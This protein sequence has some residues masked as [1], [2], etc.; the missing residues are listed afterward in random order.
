MLRNFLFYYPSQRKASDRSVLTI[1]L[2]ILLNLGAFGQTVNKFT[3]LSTS[4]NPNLT[5]SSET[6]AVAFGVRVC[7]GQFNNED[8][9]INGSASGATWDYLV[10][11][12]AWIEVKDNT[13]GGEYLEGSYAGFVVDAAAIDII[14]NVTITTYLGNTEKETRS[15]SSL[16]SLPGIFTGAS[17]IGFW[18]TKKTGGGNNNFDRIRISYSALGVVGSRTVYYPEVIRYGAGPALACNTPTSLRLS[19]GS[20]TGHPVAIAESRTGIVGTCVGCT[21]SETTSAIDSDP[22]T[23]AK[24]NML[25]SVNA[26]ASISIATVGQLNPAGTFA[27]FDISNPNVLG[28]ALGSGISIATYLNGSPTGESVGNGTLIGATTSLLTGSGRQIVG[29]KT[30][31]AF[32]EVRLSIRQTGVSLGITEVYGLVLTKFCDDTALACNKPTTAMNPANSVYVDGTH[33]KVTSLACVGCAITNPEHAVDNDPTTVAKFVTV[34]GLASSASFAVS[35]AITNYAENSFAGFEI[36][37]NSLASL[38]VLGTAT[39][40]LLYNGQPVAGSGTGGVVLGVN[41]DII[42]G[43][44]RQTIGVVAKAGVTYNGVKIT[45]NK[46]VGVDLG[47]IKIHG[48]VFQ[49]NCDGTPI[50]CETA[51]NLNLPSNPAVSTEPNFPVVINSARTGYD[52]VACVGCY[53]KDASNV[54]SASTTDFAQIGNLINGVGTSSISVFNPINTYP[55]GSTAGFTV[56]KENFLVALSLFD[57][58]RITTYN[59]GVEQEYKEGSALLN[60]NLSLQ[61]FGSTSDFY[62]VAFITQKPFDEIRISVSSLASLAD[63]YLKVYGSF[64]DTRTAAVEALR[65]YNT[66][67]DNYVMLTGTQAEGSVKVNDKVATGTTYGTPVAVSGNPNTLLPTVAQDGTYTF[68]PTLAGIYTFNVPVCLP[69]QPACFNETLTITVLDNSQS[70]NKPVANDD[71]VIVRGGAVTTPILANIIGNDGPGNS[72]GILQPPT[73]TGAPANGTATIVNGQIQYKPNAEFY[74]E[75]IVTYQIC[76]SPSG[77]CTTA[78]LVV[79]VLYPNAPNALIAS[80]DYVSLEVNQAIT[81]NAANGVLANDND[82]DGTAMVVTAQNTFIA[83]VGT[84]DL[85]ADGSYQFTPQ[86]DFRG[87]AAFTYTVCNS[88]AFCQ[89]ATLYVLSKGI[90]NLDPIIPIDNP[91]FT[92]SSSERDF[93]IRLTETLGAATNNTTITFRLSRLSGFDIT[94]PDITLN[95]NFQSGVSG[96]SDV[97]GGTNNENGEW[98]FKQ[99][100]KFVTITS[101]PNKIVNGSGIINIGFHLKRKT[102]VP[103][104]TD[105]NITVTIVAGS[106]GETDFTDN[107]SVIQVK[108]Q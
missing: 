65:C 6:C 22:A 105:Q 78:N 77:A 74:G 13:S 87:T 47:E 21:V 18:T 97:N 71:V 41:S 11:G 90:P 76:E 25:A 1:C 54:I 8:G 2:L 44:V 19:G 53:V 38:S 29:F 34:A 27:G 104:N 66:N 85:N 62:N 52:G 98:L 16:L 5:V 79:T 56:K 45:F 94:V 48:A 30:T 26:T 89:Q 59:N 64:I 63:D 84:L 93:L 80:D 39:V 35:N 102:N 23:S 107:I 31:T 106:G 36:E 14:G 82:A 88:N 75:D 95:G 32:D 17:R 50:V 46:T 73:I 49:K 33:T 69:N 68:T 86:N 3:R 60:L 4:T 51:Y 24:I 96:V 100:D 58:I 72:G 108:A 83:N 81:V 28:V 40:E 20:E 43:G 67:P 101:K 7:L 91:I 99:D 55:A 15:G 70:N 92:A 57:A 12:S 42:N 10:G 9:L 103:T 61:I 37:T